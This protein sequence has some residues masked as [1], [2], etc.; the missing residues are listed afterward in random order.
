M[1]E[2]KHGARSAKQAIAIGLSKA[3]R[4]GVKLPPPRRAKAS[5]KEIRSASR[6]AGRHRPPSARRSQAARRH[7][8]GRRA[9]PRHTPHSHVRP[10]KPRPE[11]GGG[12]KSCRTPC[13]PHT[14]AARVNVDCGSVDGLSPLRDDVRVRA[15]QQQR[16][17]AA[18]VLDGALV[19]FCRSA[20]AE[21][22]KIAA[23]SGARIFLP[24][25]QPVFTRLELSDHLETTLV[26]LPLNH[27]PVLLRAC[28]PAFLVDQLRVDV[29]LESHLRRLTNLPVVFSSF[30]AM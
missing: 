24:R 11:A 6:A 14:S 18:S 17:S 4:A 22:T 8:A 25:V 29:W 21:R 5:T 23:F 28:A 3:R 16:L 10:E 20:A 2:G 19:L 30:S 27:H 26:S 15:M 13:G 12:A 7:R 9:A 1:R